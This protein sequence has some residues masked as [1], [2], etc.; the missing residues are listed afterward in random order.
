MCVYSEQIVCSMTTQFSENIFFSYS[1]IFRA[2][3]YKQKSMQLLLM[4]KKFVSAC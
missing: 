1:S 3:N 4:K 2:I